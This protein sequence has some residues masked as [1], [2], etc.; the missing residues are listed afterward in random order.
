MLR[1]PAL[2]AA[3]LAADCGLPASIDPVVPA[4]VNAETNPTGKSCQVSADGWANINVDATGPSAPSLTI[5]LRDASYTDA[6]NDVHG[7]HTGTLDTT[8]LL[9]NSRYVLSCPDTATNGKTV[10]LTVTRDRSL[11]KFQ[12]EWVKLYRKGSWIEVASEWEPYTHNNHG[13]KIPL[14][15]YRPDVTEDL[16]TDSSAAPTDN[17]NVFMSLPDHGDFEVKYGTPYLKNDCPA[18]GC[19]P[20]NEGSGKWIA[21]EFKSTLLRVGNPWGSCG[22]GNSYSGVG[23]IVP[24]YLGHP[25]TNRQSYDDVATIIK[26]HT[27]IP[28]YVVVQMYTPTSGNVQRA[29]PT[30]PPTYYE[31]AQKWTPGTPA[32]GGEAYTTCF[33]AGTPC[34][35]NFASCSVDNCNI[36]QWNQIINDLR[37]NDNVKVL[38]YVETTDEYGDARGVE[39]LRADAQASKDAIAATTALPKAA[40]D[41]FYFGGAAAELETGSSAWTSGTAGMNNTLVVSAELKAAA[42]GT[43]TVIGTGSALM[44]PYVLEHAGAPNTVVTLS[45]NNTEIGSWAPFA[46]YPAKAASTWGAILTHVPEADVTTQATKLFDRGYGFVYLHSAAGFDTVSTYLNAALA[47]VVTQAG[48][49]RRLTEETPLLSE[50]RRLE[51]APT[52]AWGCDETLFQCSP[53]CLKTTGVVTVEV[54]DSECAGAPMDPCQCSCLY[55]AQWTCDE[56]DTVVCKATDTFALESQVVGDLVCSSRGTDKPAIGDF[57]KQDGACVAKGTVR[58]RWPTGQCVGQYQAAKATRAAAK[59]AAT[60]TTQAPTTEAPPTQGATEEATTDAPE[61][62][63][64][65]DSPLGMNVESFSPVPALAAV[66]AVALA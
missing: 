23:A 59:R 33:S 66:L 7:V 4:N 11:T 58:G 45:G 20:N 46:W 19:D 15:A 51:D 63:A 37:T 26:T 25:N 62:A 16:D 27:N 49:T 31:N 57:T 14:P 29:T 60:S 1:A 64:T 38:A 21:L 50:A 34:P 44:D 40:L 43:I 61:E 18:T 12:G 32:E 24:L 35:K 54:T 65:T 9:S 39:L 5:A 53:I 55:D 22:A 42:S 10:K 52:T 47:R 30:A 17:L 28:I 6:E 36:N 3:A 13:S 2:L 56:S 41:G 8:Q 48:S